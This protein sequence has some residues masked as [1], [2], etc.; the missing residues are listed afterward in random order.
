MYRTKRWKML[1][2]KKVGSPSDALSHTT[3]Y[4]G[5]TVPEAGR[6]SWEEFTRVYDN[7]EDN[8]YAGFPYVQLLGKIEPAGGRCPSCNGPLYKAMKP[9]DISRSDN[10]FCPYC[11]KKFDRTEDSRVDIQYNE[12]FESPD[13]MGAFNDP[14]RGDALFDTRTQAPDPTGL[15]MS[16]GDY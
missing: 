8:F 9:E 6:M 13:P 4:T 12:K 11:R 1:E 16:H 3:T 2:K 10:P 15:S 7:F 14:S 5:L